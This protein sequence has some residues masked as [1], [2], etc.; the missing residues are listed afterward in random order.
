MIHDNAQRDA[1]FTRWF[2]SMYTKKKT[3][4]QR[5]TD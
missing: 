5:L 3:L 4:I 2:C 1:I